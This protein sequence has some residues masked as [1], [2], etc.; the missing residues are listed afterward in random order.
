MFLGLAV[1]IVSINGMSQTK[2]DQPNILWIVCEDIGPYVGAYGDKGVKTPNIDQLAR[3]GTKYTK[4]FTTAGVCA[5][6][7]SSIITGMYQT[8]LGTQHMRTGGN[9]KNL[10]LAPYSAVIPSYVKCFPEYLRAAGYYCTNNVKQDYQFTPPVTVW[11]ENSAAASWRNRSEDQPFFSVFNLAITHEMNL[12]IRQKEPLSTDPNQV[13]V[14]VYYPDTE[15]ARNDIARQISNIELMDQQVGQLLD[16]LKED[17]LYENTYIFFYSDHGGALPWMKRELLDRGIHIPLVI[18][19]PNGEN[20]G[21]SDG[22]M[23]SGVD[24]P[25]TVLSLAGIPVP[26][27]MQGKAFLGRQKSKSPRKYIFAAR[28]R[29]GTE[30]DRV[31]AVRDE[32]YKYIYNYMPEKPYYQDLN[33]RKD[34]PLMKEIL[35]LKENNELDSITMTWFN[36]KQE[37]ELYDT[38]NDPNELNN[39]VN[40][41]TYRDKL[42]EMRAAF[43]VWSTT[44]GDRGELPEK[45]MIDQMW[46]NQGSAP[47]TSLPEIYESDEGIKL[48]CDTDGASI[49]YQ[50]LSSTKDPV[51]L[52]HPI[53]SWDFGSILKRVGKNGEDFSSEQP[54]SIYKPDHPIILSQ[55]DTLMVKAMRIGYEE[56]NTTYIKGE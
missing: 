54:W 42:E 20:A 13:E 25:P 3:E 45:Q 50:I 19:F 49:G 18:K 47:K 5:P 21:I 39:L 53:V 33:F 30:Y 27:Y 9:P 55:G 6:S 10:P 40:D 23:V 1:L 24:F 38:Q 14:P 46:N 41:P 15:T 37:E 52:V 34:V 2:V 17:G 35:A 16:M 28:D 44:T 7:R 22:Q 11:D 48:Y 12:F 43:H 32:R 56:A 36:T 4:A 51:S 8:S 29:M 26:L 31:R